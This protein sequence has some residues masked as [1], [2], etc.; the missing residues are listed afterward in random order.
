MDRVLTKWEPFWEQN[1]NLTPEFFF[2]CL[3]YLAAWHLVGGI[4]SS[5]LNPIN[6]LWPT[7]SMSLFL[8]TIMTWW[9]MLKAQSPTFRRTSL[10][11]GTYVLRG[12]YNAKQQQQQPLNAFH[13]CFLLLPLNWPVDWTVD[14]TPVLELSVKSL[15]LSVDSHAKNNMGWQDNP[16]RAHHA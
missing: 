14:A 7:R 6:P 13:V 8:H 10:Y 1:L 4:F 12:V 3:L 16:W 15:R 5:L 2:F 11:H 9:R